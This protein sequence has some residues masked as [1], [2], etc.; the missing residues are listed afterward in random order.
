MDLG[1]LLAPTPHERRIFANR[2][3]NLRGIEAVGYDMDYTLVHYRI[4]EWE[5]AAHEHLCEGLAKKNLPVDRLTFDP[6]FAQRGLV[7]DTQ[8]GNLVKANRFGFVKRA[9]H[10]TKPLSYPALRDEYTRTIVDLADKRWE[11]LNTFFSI[12]EAHVYAQL[13]DLLDAGELGSAIGY[14]DLYR[15]VRSTL[16]RA[17]MEG[18]LKQDVARDPERFVEHD[19]GVALAL[20]DQ[21]AAG[22][23]LLLITNSEW[24]YTDAMLN[25]ALE[26]D[27]PKGMSWRE[28]FDVVIVAARKPDFFQ[29]RPPLFEVLPPS[30]APTAEFDGSTGPALELLRP[31]PKGIT[32][33]AIF[34]GGSA[35]AV[36]SYLGLSGDQILYVGDHIYGDV[37]VSKSLL[38][39][40]TALIVR[41]LEGDIEAAERSANEDAQIASKMAEKER[42]E[43]EQCRLRLELLR[44]REGYG[45]RTEVPTD[46]LARRLSGVKDELTRLDDE[47][48]PLARA[49]AERGHAWG[50]VMRAGNDKSHFARQIERSADIYTSRVSNFALET[51]YAFLRSRRL[52]LPHDSAAPFL[53]AADADRGEPRGS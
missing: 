44:R 5:R 10:G 25:F 37:H 26:R 6:S 53:G 19:P 4:E 21:K 12:S 36:E 8:R 16:D 9:A 42:L 43:E 2:T 22:K 23:R 27:L 31:A 30:S 45:P 47:L 1:D 29:S 7:I 35:Q 39:W 32:Q 51:P 11:F 48:A 15:M 50:P 13:V 14:A 41:E 49:A 18:T 3:L 24:S 40:R 38:R 34:Y 28:L 46:D 52:T 17:H 33:N 20:L